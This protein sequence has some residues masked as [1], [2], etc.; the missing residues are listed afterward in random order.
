MDN[1]IEVDYH[2]TGR[3]I[4]S[5]QPHNDY[6]VEILQPWSDGGYFLIKDCIFPIQTSGIYVINGMDTH[7]SNPK[8]ADNYV[9]N[10]IV[11]SYDYFFQV[12]EPLSLV[13]QITAILE[14]GGLCFLP[15]H[16]P[17]QSF[18]KI[19]YLF[20]RAHEI[21]L[22][23]N[24]YRVA[25]LCHI[26]IEMLLII[27]EEIPSY[28]LSKQTQDNRTEHLLNMITSYINES[29][30]ESQ[31]YELSLDKMCADLHMSKSWICHL[32]KKHTGI[33]IIQY[34]NNLRISQAKKLL[35]TTNL[36]VHEISGMLGFSG[37]TV[38]CKTFKK[39][40]GISP[41]KYRC[42][43]HHFSEPAFIKLE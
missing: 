14:K 34:A 21:F 35:T 39:Y 12:T 22:S 18:Y 37:D 13:P 17:E 43:G 5:Y 26:L 23:G 6:A 7:C 8:D 19:D 29:I 15:S 31:N 4:R 24:P 2:A 16:S 11:V 32:F 38:F 28:D 27:V 10:K 1:F 40:T 33:P 42:D 9:R 3:D 25:K 20:R 36:K 30:N 41:Q